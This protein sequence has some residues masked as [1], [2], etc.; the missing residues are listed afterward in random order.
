VSGADGAS[1]SGRTV[2]APD[3]HESCVETLQA[4]QPPAGDQRALRD[5]YLAHL[6]ARPDGWSRRCPGA[7]L[8]ASSL[9]C[10]ADSGRVLLTLHAKI[11][12]WLQTGGHIEE[13]DDTLLAAAVREATEE[14]GLTELKVD[15]LPLLLSRHEVACGDV[16]P[17]YHL[18]VQFLVLA[19]RPD[20]PSIGAES[21][22]LQWF[23]H[24]RLPPTDSS[25]RALVAAAVERL[26]W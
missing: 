15:P 2:L 21:L 20:A 18:D 8:T 13:S 5:G 10:A 22:D 17:T 14:S 24:D 12:R 26:G 23:D 7:H 1:P 19:A 16:R 6:A 9:I 3:I 11:E 4:W 25:V